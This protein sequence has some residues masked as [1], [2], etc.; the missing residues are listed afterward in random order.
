MQVT[1]QVLRVSSEAEKA[2]NNEK[3]PEISTT[4]FAESN[5]DERE[6]EKE[7]GL[8]KRRK[9]CRALFVFPVRKG[10]EERE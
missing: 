3:N 1:S 6:R 8:I 10:N 5:S 9:P 2:E 7:Q 4:H